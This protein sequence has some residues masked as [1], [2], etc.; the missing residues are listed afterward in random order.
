MQDLKNICTRLEAQ[1]YLESLD[2]PQTAIDALL[3]E[4]AFDRHN[5]R[6]QQALEAAK[7]WVVSC[8]GMEEHKIGVH[9]VKAQASAILFADC[10][11]VGGHLGVSGAGTRRHPALVGLGKGR[12]NASDGPAW[13]AAIRAAAEH[14]RGYFAPSEWGDLCLAY[15][16]DHMMALLDFNLIPIEWQLTIAREGLRRSFGL[17]PWFP[18]LMS[19]LKA[20]E[21]NRTKWAQLVAYLTD[22]LEKARQQFQVEEQP[23]DQPEESAST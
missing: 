8:W 3:K 19:Y 1:K 9:L 7:N 14:C 12:K 23:E 20:N 2:L 17:D 6:T 18:D 10:F 21:D 4:T 15:Y 11:G 5:L 22:E 16:I 13:S